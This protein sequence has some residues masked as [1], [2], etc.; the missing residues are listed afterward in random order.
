MHKILFRRGPHTCRRQREAAGYGG[1][2][3]RAG[4]DLDR[5][6]MQFDETLHD[7]QAETGAAPAAPGAARLEPLENGG[8]HLR[9]HA[10]P[11]VVDAEF[12]RIAGL[13]RG[14]ADLAT[15][16]RVVGSI[17]QKVVEDLAHPVFVGMEAH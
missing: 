17:A 13:R 12:D 15:L 16:W 4:I 11:V 8:Q 3:V 5:T 1:S 10:G 2:A 14:K 9:W 6:A 7:G